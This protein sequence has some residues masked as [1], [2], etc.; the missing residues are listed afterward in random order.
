MP[1]KLFLRRLYR[2]YEDDSVADS[3][4][5]LSYYFVFALFP[6]LFFLA[7]L[8]AYLP[9][10]QGS[11]HTM[12]NRLRALMPAQAMGIIDGH[13][14][15]LFARPRPKLLTVGLVVALYSAARG[16]DAIRKSLNLAY[17]VKES[18][19][20]WR[21][22]LMALGVTLGGA[23]L[24]LVGVAALIA[25]G[26]MGLWVARHLGIADEYI[27]AW[28]W[29]RWPITAAVV[30]LAAALAYYFLP[31]VEQEFK[32]I[33]PGSVFGTLIWLAATWGFDQYVTNFGSYNVTYGSIGGVVVL[34]TWFYITGFVFLMGGEANAI[35]EHH[36]AEGKAQ[37][38]R[39]AGEAPPPPEE[40]PSAMPVGA[41]K[42]ADA[43]ERTR[44]GAAPH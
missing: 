2:E 20:F 28:R 26:D 3:A 42:S 22:E 32:F 11:V 34:F 27:F 5:A 13:V 25:G 19:A 8:T 44:G 35:I 39:A 43:A 30:M 1:G 18:R 10:V 12:L 38:A 14:R 36:S 41:A 9:G 33:T 37:G 7:T 16:V 21:T 29:L 17:D 23:V 6:F 24:L 40:R 31:D 4:A 15:A